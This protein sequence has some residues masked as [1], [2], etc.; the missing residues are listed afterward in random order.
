LS[1]TLG[2][3]GAH[4]L[5]GALDDYQRSVW[6]KAVLYQMFHTTALLGLGLLQRLFKAPSFAPAGWGFSAGIL[7]FSGSLYMLA[8]T[9]R[10]LFGMVTPLGGLAFLFGWIWL[11]IAIIRLRP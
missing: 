1:V 7:F 6:E 8:I 5:K 4:A 10:T 11:M 9:G 3:F 2:A